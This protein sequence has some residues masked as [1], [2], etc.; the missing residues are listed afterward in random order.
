MP[1]IAIALN[2]AQ[3]FRMAAMVLRPSLV[4]TFILASASP[5]RRKTLQAAGIEPRVSS[6]ASTSPSSGFRRPARSPARSPG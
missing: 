2:S 5:A 3:S 4:K 6:A 1:P